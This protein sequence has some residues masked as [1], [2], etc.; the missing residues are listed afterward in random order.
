M[1]C[2]IEDD[3]LLLDFASS[4]N[5]R[6]SKLSSL[7]PHPDVMLTT[8]INKFQNQYYVEQGWLT[9]YLVNKAE[10]NTN[11]E[12]VGIHNL[13]KTF[14]DILIKEYDRIVGDKPK[15]GYEFVLLQTAQTSA[16]C[17]YL[18]FL[19]CFGTKSTILSTSN[20]QKNIVTKIKSLYNDLGM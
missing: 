5:A 7:P 1:R 20:M 6:P 15:L 17:T 12:L 4:L 13:S 19:D 9:N 18:T 11:S 8:P 2:L 3:Y 10:V 16:R 14:S